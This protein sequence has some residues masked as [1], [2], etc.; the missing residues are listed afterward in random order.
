MTLLEWI[1]KNVVDGVDISEAEKMVKDLEEL[2]PLN[3][4]RTTEEAL[5]FIDRNKVF[6]SALD[7][8]TS[9]RAEHAIDNFKEK[10]LP[11]LIRAEEDRV[12]KELNPDMTEEQKRI[13]ELEAKVKAGEQKEA[14]LEMKK[15]LRAK[16]KEL[17]EKAGVQFDPILAE[18]FYVYGDKAV[19]ML[20]DTID[21]MKTSIETEL[22]KKLK[23]QFTQT[24]PK[25]GDGVTGNINERIAE[26]K[27]AG[28]LQLAAKLLI[29]K[30]QEK[31]E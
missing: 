11:G 31:S 17:S 29:Q 30:Q 3:S 6:K 2:N 7:S 22:S 26:A 20:S 19:E 25:A 24:G 5:Q 13:A 12:R 4:V 28:N 23:G 15:G 21:Y 16:A 8:E 9:K 10:K 14:E 1:K 18:R 27:K